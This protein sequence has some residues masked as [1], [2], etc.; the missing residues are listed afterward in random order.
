MD[1]QVE[2]V[3]PKLARDLGD[4]D[5]SPS[6]GIQIS[7]EVLRKRAPII[8]KLN[9]GGYIPAIG[10]SRSESRLP[11]FLIL[12]FPRLFSS[13]PA[14]LLADCVRTN[15]LAWADN[16]YNSMKRDTVRPLGTR[17]IRK[18]ISFPEGICRGKIVELW[19]LKISKV[20]MSYEREC[21]LIDSQNFQRSPGISPCSRSWP[22]FRSEPRF[23][24]QQKRGGKWIGPGCTTS[25]PFSVTSLLVCFV[26]HVFLLRVSSRRKGR[27]GNTSCTPV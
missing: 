24:A 7:T 5:S 13:T 12:S 6:S 20:L 8:E 27:Y 4:E 22:F 3:W 2:R 15:G 19:F 1:D 10:A 9:G 17:T 11:S 14:C 26:A 18:I 25:P 23:C 21:F 16:T